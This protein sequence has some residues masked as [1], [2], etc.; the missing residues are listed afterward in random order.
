MIYSMKGNVNS[1]SKRKTRM[2]L[3]LALAVVVLALV[4]LAIVLQGRREYSWFQFYLKG[5][6]AG[7]TIAE[8]NELKLAALQTKLQEPA[9]AFHSVRGFDACIKA[10]ARRQKSA[11]IEKEQKSISFIGKLYA[12]R[13][14]LERSKARHAEGIRS[15]RKIGDGQALRI[16]VQDVGV[17]ESAV[18]ENSDRYL[19]LSYP[20]GRKIPKG[21][22][23]A[24]QRIS[25]YFWRK[26][27]ASYVFDSFVMDQVEMRSIQVLHVSHSD[28]LFR[29]QKRRSIRAKSRIPA[30][31]YLLKRI[32]GA[33]EKPEKALGM[34][35][36]IQDLSEEGFAA[37]I[38][39]KAKPGL[40]VKV[41]F[42]IES[43]EVVM[44]GVTKAVEY[45]SE[46]NQSLLHV[47]ALAP[48][49]KTRSIILTYVFN[50]FVSVDDGSEAGRAR[51]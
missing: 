9:A 31:L 1:T 3:L 20:S 5:K 36:V 23:W 8:I 6:S 33:Y 26:E 51:A 29:S 4:T 15:S 19:V 46:K 38:G 43:N 40:Q 47:Q 48:S 50:A 34:R 21:F 24:G 25:I 17:Y 41:Q 16:L 13:K 12:Y 22:K 18:L 35:C 10:V 45:N 30:Y 7:F 2:I 11:G 32:E 28:S 44:S 49:A 42:M 27:D 14:K 37:F 39:G